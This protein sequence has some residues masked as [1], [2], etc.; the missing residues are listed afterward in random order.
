M[1]SFFQPGCEAVSGPRIPLS[2]NVSLR[3]AAELYDKAFIALGSVLRGVTT[4]RVED[5]RVYRSKE[6][7][8]E[9]DLTWRPVREASRICI[10]GPRLHKRPTAATSPHWL[11]Q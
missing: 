8:L 5:F 6:G 1:T 9:E 4:I 3:L 10:A 11:G 7:G 2:G